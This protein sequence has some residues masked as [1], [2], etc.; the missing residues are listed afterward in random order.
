AKDLILITGGLFL[1]Y[2]SVK[3]IFHKMEGEQGDVSKTIKATTFAQVIL[4]ILIMD[5]VFSIDSIITAIGMVREVWV[6]YV[7]VV[8]AVGIMMLAAEPIS[9]FVNK[10]PA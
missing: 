4:Q 2:K 5:L 6:M 7:A 10:H 1:L 9:K 3:E 8:V